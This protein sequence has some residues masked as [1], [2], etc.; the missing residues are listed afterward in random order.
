MENIIHKICLD[1]SLK[2]SGEVIR[3]YSSDIASRKIEA[4]F[5]S[6]VKPYSLTGISG[7]ILKAEKPSGAVIFNDCEINGERV[8]APITTALCEEAGLT[9]AQIILTSEDEK[10]LSS[11]VFF[12][13]ILSAVYSDSEILGTNEYSA[14]LGAIDEANKIKNSQPCHIVT[15][16]TEQAVEKIIISKDKNGENISLAG[17]ITIYTELPASGT[18]ANILINFNDDISGLILGGKS[19]GKRYGRC[20]FIWNGTTWENYS[21]ATGSY[22]TNTQVNTVM[23][24]FSPKIVNS[25]S[26]TVSGGFPEGTVVYVYGRRNEVES[27]G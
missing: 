12:I 19:T 15:H 24:Y 13:E 26:L 22:T 16:K 11:P 1:L 18:T 14:L 9:R 6:G 25:I 21:L 20:S 8:I 17:Q 4:E 3:C 23:K 7:A 10:V 2:T 5:R 27:N